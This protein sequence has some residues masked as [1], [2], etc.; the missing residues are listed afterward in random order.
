MID[1]ILIFE[2][3]SNH[4]LFPLTYTRPVYDLRCGILTLREKI[5]KIFSDMPLTI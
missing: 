3:D 1:S 2:D 5:G 4:L